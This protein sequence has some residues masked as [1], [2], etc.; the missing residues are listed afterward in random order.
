MSN[1]GSFSGAGSDDPQAVRRMQR[2]RYHKCGLGSPTKSAFAGLR[3]D[4]SDGFFGFLI[5]F[6]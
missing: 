1:V 6:V 4:K 5:I 3:R 2:T